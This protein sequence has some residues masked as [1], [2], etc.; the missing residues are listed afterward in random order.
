MGWRVPSLGGFATFGY[1]D[2]SDP[3]WKAWEDTRGRAGKELRFLFPVTS[4]YLRIYVKFVRRG[5]RPPGYS[6][7][8]HPMARVSKIAFSPYGDQMP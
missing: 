5:L 1:S 2:Q 4:T 8:R 3:R 6:A 7:Y